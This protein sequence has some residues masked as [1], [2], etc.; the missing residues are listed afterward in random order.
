MDQANGRLIN[1]ISK[2]IRFFSVAV[3]HDVSERQQYD[4]LIDTN[5]IYKLPF[6]LS[7]GGGIKNFFLIRKIFI[8]V[9]RH[10]DALI[11]QLPLVGFFA[12]SII[13]KPVIYHICANVITAAANKK[14][15]TGIKSLVARSFSKIMHEFHKSIFRKKDVKVIVNG[16]ELGKQYKKWY[17]QVVVSSSI[18][19]TEITSNRLPGDRVS[20]LK[21]LFI[22]R[23]S[24]QK[25]FDLLIET[26]LLFNLTG[27]I[28]ELTVIGFDE[29]YFST[30][31]KDLFIKSRPIH[32]NI[33]F[34]GY[35]NWGNEM[36]SVIREH[37]VLLVP[38]RGGEGT[39]RV[40]LECM[41]QGTPCIASKMDGIPDIIEDGKNGLL[42]WPLQPEILFNKLMT[43]T[44]DQE[45]WSNLSAGA[46][47]KSKDC[48]IEHFAFHF[49]E[50]LR[51]FK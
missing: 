38:S 45:L 51:E 40:I 6:P 25:G 16:S 20:T 10:H 44:E 19:T 11:I 7:Y 23:P 39:P 15:Y 14:K 26:L 18:R 43:L 13:K 2:S 5:Q 1:E 31:H 37:Y 36:M 24:Q 22:G 8:E 35:M 30:M 50:A 46:I 3:F 28:F 12:L 27:K 4:L 49:I 33:V 47:D 9:Q 29:T 34:K 42:F 32:K 48:T 41:S 21:L 17:P